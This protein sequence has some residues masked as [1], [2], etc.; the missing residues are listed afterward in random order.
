[1]YTQLQIESHFDGKLQIAYLNQPETYNSLNKVLLRELKQFVHDCSHSE[2]VRCVAI[3]GRGKAFCSG[4]NLKDAMSMN[5][6]EEERIIQRMVIDYYNPLVNEI[7]NCRKPVISLV[8][9]PAVGAGAMLALICDISLA[10]QSSYFSQAFVNIGLIPD[11]GG[12]YWLPKLLG[13]QQANYLAFTGK[14]ISATEA[15]QIGLIADV[16][17]DESFLT[18]AMGVLEQISNLPTKAIALTKK[19]FNESYDNS[20]SKQLDVEGIL[21]QEAAETEDFREGVTAFLEKRKPNYR[22]R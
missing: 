13:R 20:L 9:G 10:T 4:Q 6:P 21:Q 1:M 22:G 2:S 14:K 17:E 3:S 19:A 8:N 5:D 11:T 18:N 7:A 15:K 16:F 12:T